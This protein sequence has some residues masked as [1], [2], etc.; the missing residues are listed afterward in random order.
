[1]LDKQNILIETQ[2]KRRNL[3]ITLNA[4]GQVVVT[5]PP[6]TPRSFIDQLLAKNQSWIEKRIQQQK[7]LIPLVTKTTVM[8]FGQAYTKTQSV[9]PKKL[10][11]FYLSGQNLI[12]NPVDTLNPTRFQ[13]TQ[14]KRFLKL[15][16]SQYIT[17]K[18]Q[19]IAQKM[20]LKPTTIGLREQSSRWGSCSSRGHLSFN[21]HLVHFSPE[22]IDYV[23]IHELAHLKQANH[24]QYFWELVAK[25]DSNYQTHRRNLKKYLLNNE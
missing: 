24:S 17:P 23:I 1:M 22:I 8:I 10:P 3:K 4:L 15:T 16:A 2:S 9:L 13:N 7:K 18:T 11:G 19:V 6:H 21:W 5:A 12:F 25:F 14:L 20:D